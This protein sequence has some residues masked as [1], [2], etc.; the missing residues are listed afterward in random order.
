MWTFQRY[1]R[2][3]DGRTNFYI[4]GQSPESAEDKTPDDI[5][6]PPP[7]PQSSPANRPIGTSMLDRPLGGST[8]SGTPRPATS[9]GDLRRIE[10][11]PDESGF[12]KIL[13]K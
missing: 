8:P 10:I 5:P 11:E 12:G 13:K 6:M 7:L 4:P 2:W 1:A 9:T 3:L